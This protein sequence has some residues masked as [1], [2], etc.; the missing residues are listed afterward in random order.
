MVE[1]FLL[2]LSS[3]SPFSVPFSWKH[4]FNSEQGLANTPMA[5]SNGP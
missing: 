3:S 4:S 1:A 2:L 5:K